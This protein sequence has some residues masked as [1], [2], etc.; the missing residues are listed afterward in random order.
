[1]G[2]TA[3][4]HTQWLV[5]W[6]P[7]Y[8]IRTGLHSAAREVILLGVSTVRGLSAAAAATLLTDDVIDATSPARAGSLPSRWGQTASAGIAVY[9][10]CGP[11]ALRRKKRGTKPAGPALEA[12]E[13]VLIHGD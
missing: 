5:T 9:P 11:S 4:V 1:M 8:G 7:H 12:A 3:S 6:R 2:T 13:S 10:G